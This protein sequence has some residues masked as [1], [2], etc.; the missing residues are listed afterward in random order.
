[1]IWQRD[2]Y[3]SGLKQ[4]FIYLKE[5]KES[6]GNESSSNFWLSPGFFGNYTVGP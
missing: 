1:M 6:E 4:Y 2:V 5:S 3:Y